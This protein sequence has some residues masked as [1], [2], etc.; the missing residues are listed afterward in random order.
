M[1]A[2]VASLLA[3]AV[4]A[5]SHQLALAPA[6][7]RYPLEIVGSLLVALPYVLL[8]TG[9]AILARRNAQGTVDLP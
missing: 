6:G 8:F 2:V 9:L 1:L 3:G 7:A 4:S 5:N